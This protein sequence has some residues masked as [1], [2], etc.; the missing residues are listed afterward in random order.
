M[1]LDQVDQLFDENPGFRVV[2]LLEMD[3]SGVDPVGLRQ[4]NLDLMDATVPGI[5]NITQHIRPYAFMAWAWWKASQYASRHDLSPVQV[6]DLVE[7]YEALYAWSHSM[8]GAPFRG[9]VTV[10]KYLNPQEGAD[11]FNFVGDDWEAYKKERT[12]FM[13]PTEYGPSIKS[14]RFLKPE[15]GMF[16]WATEAMPAIMAIDAIISTALPER[17]LHP[18]PP[19]VTLNEIEPL[20]QALSIDDPTQEE[21]NVFRHLFYEIGGVHGAAKDMRRRKATIDLLRSLLRDQGPMSIDDI[22]RRLAVL[23]EVVPYEG[24]E[25]EMRNSSIMLCHLQIRQLQRIATESMMMWVEVFLSMDRRRSRTMD[26][27]VESA[28]SSALAVDQVYA[29][30]ETVGDYLRRIDETAGDHGWPAAAASPM[31]DVI[32]LLDRVR[33]AQRSDITQVPALVIRSFAVVRAVTRSFDGTSF[34]D[35]VLNSME[36][37][38]DRMPMG[39][40]TRKMEVLSS[41]PLTSLWKE[42]VEGWIIGQHVHWSAVRGGDGKKRLRIGLEGDGWLLVR[43][44]PSRGFAATPDRLLTLLSLGSACGLFST[45]DGG[46][47]QA[48]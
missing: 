37:R 22:R 27:I 7:R 42:I 18:E 29:E 2:S 30:C 21:K 31:T 41:R 35:G 34:Q 13:A 38:P 26:E 4:L 23:G 8:A 47:Y 11:V 20:A 9:N 39:M 14:I 25:V 10:R 28:H 45:T 44:N 15:D 46:R 43:P 5:N 32:D 36:A 1:R 17:L 3:E 12:S 48:A 6:I 33:R 40:M 16:G 19:A 24:D